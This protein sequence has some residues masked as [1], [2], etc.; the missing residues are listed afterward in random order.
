MKL[1][2]ILISLKTSKT[3]KK[4]FD[5]EFERDKFIR[6]SRFFTNLKVYDIGEEYEQV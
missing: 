6:R 1:Y 5:T 3:F 2:L 4:Y